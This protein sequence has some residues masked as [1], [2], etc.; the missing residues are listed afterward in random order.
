[1]E[2][3]VKKDESSS[4]SKKKKKEIPFL[5]LSCSKHP[6]K[7]KSGKNRSLS[8]QMSGAEVSVATRLT[9]WGPGNNVPGNNLILPLDLC[10][11]NSSSNVNRTAKQIIES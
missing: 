8:L 7:K 6:F 5:L 10:E 3:F 9:F 1:M 2:G 11:S 4:R